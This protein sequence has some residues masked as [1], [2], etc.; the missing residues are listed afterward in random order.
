[1]RAVQRPAEDLVIARFWPHE[2]APPPLYVYCK[3]G[4]LLEREAFERDVARM[5]SD[6]HLWQGVQA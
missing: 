2:K 5:L 1:M 4:E 6:S 3:S